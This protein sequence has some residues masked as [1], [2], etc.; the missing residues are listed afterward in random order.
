MTINRDKKT[1][2]PLLEEYSTIRPGNIKKCLRNEDIPSE[3]RARVQVLETIN[4]FYGYLSDTEENRP[5]ID[6]SG[7]FAVRMAFL[8]IDVISGKRCALTATGRFRKGFFEYCLHKA[9]KAGLSEEIG[10]DELL[11][12]YF[13][14]CLH[15]LTVSGIVRREG[16][17]AAVSCASISPRAMFHRL[18]NSFWNLVRWEEIFASD[19]ESARELKIGRNI[20]KDLVLRHHGAVSLSSIANE[21]FDLTGFSAPNDLLAVSFLDFYFFTWLRH[22]S[23][24]RYSNGPEH[25]PVRITVTDAGRTILSAI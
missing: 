8:V 17:R 3:N 24:I 18:F 6:M 12:I 21:F 15:L 23:M 25:A 7:C 5:G 19:P 11:V 20:L 16:D 9:N 4:R 1:K 10:D 13:K 2:L 22:F 14:Q